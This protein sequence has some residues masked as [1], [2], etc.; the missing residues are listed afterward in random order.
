MT[1]ETK[2]KTAHLLPLVRY[3]LIALGAKLTSGGWLPPEVAAAIA[4]DP[5]VIEMAMGVVVWT[6]TGLWY[7]WSEAKRALD[8]AFAD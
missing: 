4:A 5:H 3:G 6:G 1:P 7:Y 8:S 2:R